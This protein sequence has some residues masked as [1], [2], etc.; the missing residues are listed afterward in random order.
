MDLTS[1]LSSLRSDLTAAA[2]AGSDETRRTAELLSAAL[3]SSA[4]L[5]LVDALSAAAAEITARLADA[6]GGLVEI[7]MRGRDPE[8]V[9][10]RT[11]PVEAMGA[12]PPPPGPP[13]SPAAPD[14][15]PDAA[16]DD[17]GTARITVRLPESVK[18]RSDRRA[19]E[20]GMSLNAWIV[21][22]ITDALGGARDDD[23][24]RTTRRRGI[25]THIT[26][27]AQS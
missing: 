25:G 11:P 3:E 10:L 18:T 5:C 23:R 9:V 13:G 20:E 8:I 14:A 16:A 17:L 15:A 7:R 24:Q 1:Y 4:R 27:Y 12:P 2:G 6:G 19:A 21:R 26:G 22:A